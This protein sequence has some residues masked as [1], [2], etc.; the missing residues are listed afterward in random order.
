MS[1]SLSGRGHFNEKVLTNTGYYISILGIS[2]LSEDELMLGTLEVAKRI[3]VSKSTLL[4]W[5]DDGL[6]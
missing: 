5:L 3:G 1:G 6:V 2:I 4:R